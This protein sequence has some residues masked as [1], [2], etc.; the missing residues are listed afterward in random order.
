[1]KSGRVQEQATGRGLG[2]RRDAIGLHGPGEAKP[3]HTHAWTEG[4][5]T[6][7]F[8]SI[9]TLTRRMNAQVKKGMP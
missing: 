1:M 9:V 8:S 6:L 7:S 4:D 2:F 3:R 5:A